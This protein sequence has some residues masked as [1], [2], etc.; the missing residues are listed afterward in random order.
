L[1]GSEL[2]WKTEY[3]AVENKSVKAEN[4]IIEVEKK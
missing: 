1:E 2:V 3:P 4:N